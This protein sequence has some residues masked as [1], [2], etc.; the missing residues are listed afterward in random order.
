MKDLMISGLF[1]H[2]CLVGL[3][4]GGLSLGELLGLKWLPF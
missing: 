2:L 1:H 4:R 3:V